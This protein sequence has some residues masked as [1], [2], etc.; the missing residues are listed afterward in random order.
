MNLKSLVLIALLCCGMSIEA[1]YR[2][3]TEALKTKD[4]A[5]AAKE[6]KSQAQLGYAK[7]TFQFAT[8]LKKAQTTDEYTSAAL[9]ALA[10]AQGDKK[11]AREVKRVVRGL[12]TTHFYTKTNIFNCNYL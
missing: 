11:A 5:T 4:Y 2:D 10:E 9:F 7:A 12:D 6:F 8:M 1:D 3:G